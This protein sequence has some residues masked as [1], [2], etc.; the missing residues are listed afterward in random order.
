MSRRLAFR[1]VISLVTLALPTIISAAPASALTPTDCAGTAKNSTIPNSLN[2]PSGATCTLLGVTVNGSVFTQ[3]GS[4]L[5]MSGTTVFGNVTVNGGTIQMHSGSFDAN[6]NFDPR[7]RTHVYGTVSVSNAHGFG[8]AYGALVCGT[9]ISGSVAIS[10]ESGPFG[11][12]FVSN[13]GCGEPD[14]G[15]R[16]GGTL[17]VVNNQIGFIYLAGTSALSVTL[18]NNQ[19]YSA[20]QNNTVTTS[21]LCTGNVPT[22]V[23]FGNTAGAKLG[24]CATL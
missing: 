12:I 2:V 11:Q 20:I 22:P 16:I 8:T 14:S 3:P 9:D 6:N 17:A 13:F 15:N 19:G 10:G 23:G 5:F 21:L 4:Q 1:C 7:P 18:V 24:Q